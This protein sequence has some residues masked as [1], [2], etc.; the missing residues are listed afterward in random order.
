MGADDQVLTGVADVRDLSAMQDLATRAVDRFG[1]I[2]VVLANAGIISFGSVL[3]M[4]PAVF[5]RVLDVDL[6]GSSTLCG[7]RCPP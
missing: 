3:N 6:L 5:K 2:D 7:P 1:G 4:D